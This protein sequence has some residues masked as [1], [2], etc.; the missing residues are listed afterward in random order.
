MMAANSQFTSDGVVGR[1]PA[2]D[3]ED[4]AALQDSYEHLC[5]L[6][7]EIIAAGLL[8]PVAEWRSVNPNL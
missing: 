7:D 1:I 3:A 8:P 4:M 2:G 5:K 6:R